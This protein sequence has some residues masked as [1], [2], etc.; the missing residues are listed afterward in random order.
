MITPIIYQKAENEMVDVLPILS[1]MG[2]EMR[3]PMS[4]PA[5]R[6]PTMVPWRT[7]LNCP[8]SPNLSKKLA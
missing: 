6:R 1:E 2:A 3:Q 8:F 5:E 4:V 7:A